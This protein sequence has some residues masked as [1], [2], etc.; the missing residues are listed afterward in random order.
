M[1][2]GEG[3]LRKV[4]TILVIVAAVVI[5]ILYLFSKSSNPV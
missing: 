3:Q 5:A 1:K 4:E 2:I